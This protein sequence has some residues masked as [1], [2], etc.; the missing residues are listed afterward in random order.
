MRR[1]R[2]IFAIVTFVLR[3][4]KHGNSFQ[5]SGIFFWESQSTKLSLKSKFI[6]YELVPE[7]GVCQEILLRAAPSPRRAACIGKVPSQ[8][9]LV[10]RKSLGLFFL[11]P[12]YRTLLSRTNHSAIQQRIHH[13]NGY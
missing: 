11:N 8:P 6:A 7:K 4:G 12:L 10:A 2:L 3:K 13:K 5:N 1:T 9:K